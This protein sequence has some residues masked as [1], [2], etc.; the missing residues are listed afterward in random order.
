MRILEFVVK[1]LKETNHDEPNEPRQQMENIFRNPDWLGSASAT[2]NFI[3]P[4]IL[5]TTLPQ[6]EAEPL[7]EAF[8]TVANQI[9]VL[10]IWFECR[11]VEFMDEDLSQ[12]LRAEHVLPRRSVTQMCLRAKHR[13]RGILKVR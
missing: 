12:V 3:V 2:T 9:S 11:D 1:R 5:G 8:C 10:D 4:D 6:A 13:R 7:A